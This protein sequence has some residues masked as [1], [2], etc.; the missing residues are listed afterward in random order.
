MGCEFEPDGNE[1]GLI[2]KWKVIAIEKVCSSAYYEGYSTLQEFDD[3][4][5]VCFGSDST[6]YFKPAI[7]YVS[8]DMESFNWTFDVDDVPPIESRRFLNLIFEDDISE[9][10][11]Y[12]QNHPDSI[13]F[14]FSTLNPTGGLGCAIFYRMSLVR[15]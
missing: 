3:T 6:G 9:Q 12:Y 1:T 2:G 8:S 10:S 7:P 11:F 4:F 13:N 14:F 5:V 15:K